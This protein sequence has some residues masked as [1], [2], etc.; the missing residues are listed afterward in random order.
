MFAVK[1]PIFR[2]VALL[3]LIVACVLPISA[4]QA[5][6]PATVGQWSAPVIWPYLAVHA[7]VL[8]SGKVMWWPSFAAGDNPI[9]WD[10][11]TGTNTALVRSGANLFC[12]GHS[13]LADGQLF[14][15]G[16]HITDWVGLPDAYTYNPSNWYLD[17]AA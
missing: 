3:S 14:V 6:T 11:S 7:H 10:P 12:A 9:Q 15:A 13:F 17:A 2:F 16:G 4:S 8:P 5:Q 1:R